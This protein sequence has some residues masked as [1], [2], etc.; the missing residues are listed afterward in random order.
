MFY[1]KDKEL[2]EGKYYLYLFNNDTGVSKSRPDLDW[3][4]IGNSRR[5]EERS[6]IL[7][8]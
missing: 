4:Q 2:E 5:A 1:A 6:K 8:L 3:G 7:L